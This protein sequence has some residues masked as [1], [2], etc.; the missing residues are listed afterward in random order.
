[1]YSHV[2]QSTEALFVRPQPFGPD[3]KKQLENNLDRKGNPITPHPSRFEQ[4][5]KDARKGA[6]GWFLNC[7]SLEEYSERKRRIPNDS[8]VNKVC[9]FRLFLVDCSIPLWGWELNPH[10]TAA[11]WIW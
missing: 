7:F 11:Q 3:G 5:D 10:L 1:M 9:D 4:W 8:V 6:S 2:H